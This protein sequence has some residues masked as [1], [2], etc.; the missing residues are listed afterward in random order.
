MTS[1]GKMMNG[2]G[3]KSG[4]APG[5]AGDDADQVGAF[6]TPPLLAPQPVSGRWSHTSRRRYAPFHCMMH[7]L[8][9]AAVCCVKCAVEDLMQR[10]ATK[11]W[12]AS[13][14]QTCLKW[15][16]VLPVQCLEQRGR[17]P[18]LTAYSQRACSLSAPQGLA[19]APLPWRGHPSMPT[20][21]RWR[22]SAS[23]ATLQALARQR[24][25]QRCCQLP[26]RH[27]TMHAERT[28]TGFLLC[29]CIGTAT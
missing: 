20:G 19:G 14:S 6:S 2:L 3:I 18:A 10:C 24:T 4:K 11:H 8:L 21:R 5:P 9:R 12:A 1:L 28:L 29:T 17:G 23:A 7:R 26:S 13:L 16:T 15:A 22:C 25:L 27:E